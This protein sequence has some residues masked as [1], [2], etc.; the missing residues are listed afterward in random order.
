MDQFLYA[1]LLFL[2]AVVLVPRSW[3]GVAV[4]DDFLIARRAWFFP[5]LFAA[6]ALEVFDSYL[7]GGWSYVRDSGPWTWAFGLLT[8]PVRVVGVRS[9]SRRQHTVGWRCH[10]PS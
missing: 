7:K 1:V 10:D 2:L 6:T 8:I 4:L 5:L 3:D 9:R